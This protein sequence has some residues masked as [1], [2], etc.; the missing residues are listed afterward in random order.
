MT[1]LFTVAIERGPF[2]A[3]Q[4]PQITASAIAGGRQVVRDATKK[5]QPD[6]SLSV[7][8]LLVKC[9]GRKIVSPGDGSSGRTA[10]SGTSRDRT[11]RDRDGAALHASAAPIRRRY[12]CIS[13]NLLPT[14]Q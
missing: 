12:P 6:V 8:T 13:H 4:R 1:V 11:P 14:K 5:L 2:V 7:M 9:P 3:R 10:S